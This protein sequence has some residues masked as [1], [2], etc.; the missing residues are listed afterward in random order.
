MCERWR[1]FDGFF[2]DMGH[3]PDGASLDRINND[4]GYQKSNCRWASRKE[5]ARN[6]RNSRIVELDGVQMSL[7][8]ACEIAGANYKLAH[9]RM[10]R[11]CSFE[12]AI[13]IAAS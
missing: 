6:K 11:G 1:K 5:Q 3:P 13:G 2:E 10:T 4:E 8:E 7:A 9:A 12:E